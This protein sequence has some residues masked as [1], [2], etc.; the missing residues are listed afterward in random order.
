MKLFEISA[1]FREVQAL[2]D[3]DDIPAEVI[4][5]T[6]E[7]LQGDFEEKAVAVAQ[8]VLTLEANAKAI[9][10]IAKRM[11]ERQDRVEKRAASLKQYLLLQLQLVDMKKIDRAD[12]VIRRQ[13]NPVSV[14]VL[15]DTKVPPKWWRQP[16]PPPKVIDR[17]ALKEALQGGAQVDGVFLES[18]E[19]VRISI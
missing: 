17:K 16:P 7:G 9:E 4:V 10:A 6:L 3:S 12:I 15:D 5:D 11:M 18:G 14:V 13:A 1:Q 19:H 2:L 8:M